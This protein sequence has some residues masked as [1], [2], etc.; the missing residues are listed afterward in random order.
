MTLVSLARLRVLIIDD[1]RDNCEVYEHALTQEGAFVVCAYDGEQGLEIAKVTLPDVI[2]LDLGL[3]TI[4]GWEV[5]RR[6]RSDEATRDVA[7]VVCTAHATADAH[8][9]ALEAGIDTFL[10]KPC[11]PDTLV[12]EIRN[13]RER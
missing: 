6:L 2:V 10:V 13:L 4:D 1:V 12:T 8:K 7:I 11:S 5:A 9:R 3:P